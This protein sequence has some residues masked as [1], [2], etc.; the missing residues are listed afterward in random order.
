VAEHLPY[1]WALVVP[2]ELGFDRRGL[3]IR[4]RRVMV[5]PFRDAR[6]PGALNALLKDVPAPAAILVPRWGADRRSPGRQTAEALNAA[7]PRW[8]ELASF[9]SNDVL[10]NYLWPT[11]WGDPAFSIKV[12]K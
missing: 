9:G 11:A 2:S 7:T 5:M 8:R 10:V 6:D 1:D 3:E 4:S 12:L